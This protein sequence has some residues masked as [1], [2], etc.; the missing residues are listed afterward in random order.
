MDVNNT[1]HWYLLNAQD[2]GLNE[3][4][5]EDHLLWSSTARALQLKP[6]AFHFPT[7][8]GSPTTNPADRRGAARDQYG[9]FFWISEDRSRIRVR[10]ADNHVADYWPF[11][12]QESSAQ[13]DFQPVSQASMQPLILYG[14]CIT[15]D[16]YLVV[17]TDMPA[18]LLVFDLEGSAPPR[19]LIWPGDIPF[20]PFE[21][22]ATSAGGLWLLDVAEGARLWLFDSTLRLVSL[23][24]TTSAPAAPDFEPVSGESIELGPD[25]ASS[26]D[27]EMAF[28]LVGVDDVVSLETLPNDD[29][30]LL[31]SSAQRGFSRLYHCACNQCY[32]YVDLDKD[33]FVALLDE[34]T[35]WVGKGLLGYDLAYQ[36]YNGQPLIYV[37]DANGNQVFAFH[38]TP[39]ADGH[40][41]QLSLTPNYL[42]LAHFSGKALLGTTEGVWYD[43]GDRWLLLR[44][45][46]RPRFDLEGT[47]VTQEMDSEITG[48]VWHRM[49]IDAIIPPDNSLIIEA[50]S[51]ENDE[52]L[53]NVPWR[54]QPQ[55]YR[56]S[57]AEIPFFDPFANSDCSDGATW[58]TYL[59]NVEGRYLQLRFTLKGNGRST[60]RVLGARIYYPRFSYLDNYLPALFRDE[61]LSANFL[62]RYL[63]N[64][65]GILSAWENRIADAQQLIDVD[66]TPVEFLPWLADWLGL[67]LESDW[68]EW[69]RRHFLKHAIT[70]FQ[71]RGTMPGILRAIRL[72]TD[73]CRDDGLF[74]EPFDERIQPI[75]IVEDFRRRSAPGVAIGA[76]G[77]GAFPGIV[78]GSEIWDP[79]Q[80]AAP[81]DARFRIFLRHRYDEDL[82]R[83]NSAWDT[84]YQAFDDIVMPAIQPAHLQQ[85]RDWEDFVRSEIGFNYAEITSADTER[86]RRFISSR[87]R[88]LQ[89]YR[90]AY[91]GSTLNSFDELILP[92][93]LPPAGSPLEDWIQFVSILMPTV[94]LA[95][96]FTV[97]VPGS[98]QLGELARNKILERI[99]RVVELEKPG[100]TLFSIKEYWAFFRVGEARIGLDTTVSEGA[101]MTRLFLNRGYL[102]HHALS[103]VKG[104]S[105]RLR[106]GR[107][108]S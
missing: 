104:V 28:E 92:S 34:G 58:E 98:L 24:G 70:L 94:R 49:L 75:R 90:L 30:L 71:Q 15:R 39:G 42:P 82:I 29:V 47:I 93:V 57:R 95:H 102:G 23:N 52:E 18:G 85:R 88:S 26:I 13:T 14:L 80:G 51:H 86:Y 54:E 79:M 46:R 7:P 107:G 32:E 33:L 10:F 66:A 38:F 45:H 35:S 40:A 91:P 31:E 37:V 68:E 5:P 19:Q 67:V 108:C 43:S 1:K 103:S 61:P 8:P 44:S 96:R 76:P 106:L 27:R 64:V 56:R 4:I 2:W 84:S 97:L 62:D 72:A 69:R 17:G 73:T 16:H 36:E 53:E 87:Y 105:S 12:S 100:H 78:A 11:P 60:L 89:A 63:G 9:N 48:C 50:R 101:R 6:R 83:L 59:Q 25:V 22:S 41:P 99:R 20:R 3:D 74:V 65:E 55:P 77:A 81:L 21:L